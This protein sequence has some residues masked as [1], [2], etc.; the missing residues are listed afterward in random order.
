MT[1]DHY[2]HQHQ[3]RVRDNG[4][5]MTGDT[6]CGLH[7]WAS[8]FPL[9]GDWKVEAADSDGEPEPC[10]YCGEVGCTE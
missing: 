7:A 9:A 3:L 2:I 10:P 8:T 4:E 5:V 1:G 6:S